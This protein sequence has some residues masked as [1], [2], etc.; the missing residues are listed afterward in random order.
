MRAVRGLDIRGIELDIMDGGMMNRRDMQL[1]KDGMILGRHNVI[2]ETG[3]DIT[4]DIIILINDLDQGARQGDTLL[5]VGQ[6]R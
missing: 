3:A 5:E 2:A 4:R 1:G 6:Y